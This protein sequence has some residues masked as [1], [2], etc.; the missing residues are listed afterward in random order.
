MDCTAAVLGS[1][2]A[3]AKSGSN[4]GA[5]SPF[6]VFYLYPVNTE[7]ICKIARKP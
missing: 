1:A 3:R 2:K 6:S 7:G 4:Q 5:I